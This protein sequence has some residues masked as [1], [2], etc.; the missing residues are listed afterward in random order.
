[1]G[2][3]GACGARRGAW[4]PGSRCGWRVCSD[5]GGCGRAIVG[6]GRRVAAGRGGPWRVQVRSSGLSE[7]PPG[8]VREAQSPPRSIPSIPNPRT[9]LRRVAPR[10]RSSALS[11]PDSR[12][13]PRPAPGGS[14]PGVVGHAAIGSH[15]WRSPPPATPRHT[16]SRFKRVAA[17]TD[18]QLCRGSRAPR[19]LARGRRDAPRPPGA[20]RATSGL[21]SGP[22]VPAPG[23]TGRVSAVRPLR[24]P[25]RPGSP[26]NPKPTPPPAGGPAPP[27]PPRRAAWP[28][29]APRSRPW[30]SPG[31]GPWSW[32]R[33]SSWPG[34]PP[35]SRR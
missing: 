30:T 5:D 14:S 18:A 33:A 26:A 3:L 10:R 27:S 19:P 17:W 35:R 32:R 12:P 8:S 16:A 22:R 29:R 23:S 28:L 6:R 25:R 7:I 11:R 24:S 20:S 21:R 13:P 15:T 1:M 2:A 9:C 31:P 4:E 34:T